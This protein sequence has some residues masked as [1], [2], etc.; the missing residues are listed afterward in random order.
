NDMIN[1]QAATKSEYVAYL[2]GIYTVSVI[3]KEGCENR[4]DP[5]DGIGILQA[6]QVYT[7]YQGQDD[8]IVVLNTTNTTATA[9]IYH[10]SGKLMKISTVVPGYNEIP[11]DRTGVFIVSVT[12]QNSSQTT[13]LLFH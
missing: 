1:S 12:G 8:R 4:Q 7:V 9:N 6:N 10:F 2:P 3:N 11:F 5:A 13:R